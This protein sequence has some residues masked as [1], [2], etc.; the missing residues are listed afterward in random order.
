MVK[1][2]TLYERIGVNPN[3][4]QEEIQ[5]AYRRKSKLV[6]PDRFTNEK[7]K[8]EA[9]IKFQELGQAKEILLNEEKRR[10]YDQI[11]MDIFKNGM[12][13]DDDGMT[14][15]N[16][17]DFFSNIFGSMGGFPSFGN[18]KKEEKDI[19]CRLDVTLE[20]IY[21]AQTINHTYKY[22]SKCSTCSGTGS[23][24]GKINKC[25]KCN[26]NGSI[27]IVRQMGPM[28]IQQ[29]IPCPLCE[30][31]CKV[32]DKQNSC[33]TCSG[34]G[35]IEKERTI[36][37]PLNSGLSQGDKIGL[38]GKGH[39]LEN[40]GKLILVINELPHNIFKRVQD[41][42]IITIELKLYQ[43][44]FGFEKTINFLD[45][46]KLLISSKTRTEH[47]TIRKIPNF[48]MKSIHSNTS[49]DLLI[50]FIVKMPNLDSIP[51]DIKNQIKGLLL[52]FDKK[53][54]LTEQQISKDSSLVKTIME[55]IN[56]RDND[57]VNHLL[58]TMKLRS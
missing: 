34:N 26:G 2:T 21:N 55:D 22:K 20:Q 5:K 23:K 53:E 39:H 9:T 48:G 43:A 57:A 29:E 46:Q 30:G 37:V 38:E 6:H 42:L 10:I 11:G 41:N 51:S 25:S 19:I 4:S 16:P 45:G 3:A 40:R 7:E 17:G 28:I 8:E 1:D 31:K 32:I 27:N 13:Q 15:M 12:D 56:E 52:S 14:G 24:D 58:L 47:G 18:K 36:S 50:Q 44:L 49:G 35:Y 54:F 33:S